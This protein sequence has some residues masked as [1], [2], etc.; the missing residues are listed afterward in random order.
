MP[1]TMQTMW[2]I[3]EYLCITIRAFA[4]IVAMKYHTHTASAD[5]KHVDFARRGGKNYGR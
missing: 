2:Q 4:V 5:I 3:E 1:N